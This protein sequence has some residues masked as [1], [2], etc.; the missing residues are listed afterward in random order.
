MEKPSNRAEEDRAEYGTKRPDAELPESEAVVYDEP[1][2]DLI[3]ELL[4]QSMEES[5]IHGYL[6]AEEV[7][8]HIAQKFGWNI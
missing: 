2:D 4:R 8:S 5:R 6:S 3:R 1:S 7:H